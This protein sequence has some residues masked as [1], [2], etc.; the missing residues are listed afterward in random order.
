MDTY[1]PLTLVGAFVGVGSFTYS[2]I[3]LLK[4]FYVATRILVMD[5][6][7]PTYHVDILV[8]VAVA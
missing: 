8:G 2:I 4:G 5:N 3:R 6:Y 1:L 7:V